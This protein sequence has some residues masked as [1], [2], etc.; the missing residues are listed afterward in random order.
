MGTRLKCVSN[1][2]V[3]LAADQAG[4]RCD[5]GR[6]RWR[7]GYQTRMGLDI[8]RLKAPLSPCN[9]ALKPPSYG[10]NQQQ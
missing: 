5:D 7:S 9:Q 4:S 10:L 2:Y 3:M 6:L 8:D 1:E